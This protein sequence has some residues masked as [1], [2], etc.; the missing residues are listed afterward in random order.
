MH[1]L[2]YSNHMQCHYLGEQPHGPKKIIGVLPPPPLLYAHI[3][4]PGRDSH[5]ALPRPSGI[6]GG[7]IWHH[8][9]PTKQK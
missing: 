2:A 8:H 6:W 1:L 4:M 3:G 5:P 7:G 9:P